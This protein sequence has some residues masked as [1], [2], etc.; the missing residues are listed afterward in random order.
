MLFCV[1]W[2]GIVASATFSADDLTDSEKLVTAAVICHYQPTAL[3]SNCQAQKSHYKANVHHGLSMIRV[4]KTTNLFFVF[5]ISSL[6]NVNLLFQ[7]P[8][9]KVRDMSNTYFLF[10]TFDL[11]LFLPHGKVTLWRSTRCGL[12]Q[13]HPLSAVKHSCMQS[14]AGGWQ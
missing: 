10:S 12:Q 14:T 6:R 4:R 11:W 7:C 8:F 13:P 5:F 9:V 3:M 2:G 1:F